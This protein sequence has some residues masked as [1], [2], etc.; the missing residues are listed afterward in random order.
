MGA[1][2]LGAAALA[3][4]ST[5]FGGRRLDFPNLLPAGIS[6]YY[7]GIYGARPNEQ[8]PIPAVDLNQLDARYLRAEVDD[9]TGE[10]PGTIVVETSERY[11]YFVLP[12]RRAIRYGV[13]IGREGFQWSGRGVVGRKAKWP[14]WV[15]TTQ[16]QQR[17]PETRQYAGGMPGGL[18]NPLG[19]RALYIYRNGRDTLY[20]L[21]GTPEIWSIGRDVSSGCVRLINQDVIDL[22]EHAPVGT[23]IIVKA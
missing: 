17:Q 12:G 16:M 10:A 15:P 19:A 6:P 11:L 22:Y 14:T 5:E 20:R 4:C 23:P 2:G 8:F 7:L 21:H 18:T 3:G 13:G 1:G 9:P